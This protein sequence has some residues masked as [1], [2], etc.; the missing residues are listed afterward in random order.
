[1][2]AAIIADRSFAVREQSLLSRLEIGLADE[3]V[4]VVHAVPIECLGSES[5]G[6]YSTTV[7]Y[8]D[9]GFAISRLRRAQEL[10]DTVGE[11]LGNAG[12]IDVVHCFGGAAWAIG[13]EFARLAGAPLIVEVERADELSA[14]AALGGSRGAAAPAMFLCPDPAIGEAMLGRAPGAQVNTVPWGVH[15]PSGSRAPFDTGSTVTVAVLVEH[16]AGKGA[17]AALEALASAATTYPGLLAFFSIGDGR[18]DTVWKQARRLNLLERLSINSEME[19]RREPIL[20]ADLLLLPDA[21]GQQHSLTL[22][23]MAAG[24]V[25]IAAAD[26]MNSSLIDGRTARL[27]HGATGQAWQEAIRR[28]LADPAAAHAL[29]ASAGEWVGRERSVSAHV[30]GV[31]RA[32]GAVAKKK[33]TAAA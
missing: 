30:S 23:A 15:G 16:G 9:R 29:A 20:Q 3:G 28:T 33:E 4:R 27:V 24:M 14:A 25:V 10:L 26:R 2:H 7:G 5:V 1:V 17:A 32:Y 18:D 12:G 13:A 21:S 22:D 31:L 19:A 8:Q 11:A 6:L